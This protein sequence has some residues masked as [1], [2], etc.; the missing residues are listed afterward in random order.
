MRMKR[1]KI[2]PLII[3]SAFL[4]VQGMLFWSFEMMPHEND[5]ACPVLQAVGD[6]P[7]EN[8][9]AMIQHHLSAMEKF[10]SGTPIASY[11]LLVFI[12]AVFVFVAR[13]VL[14]GAQGGVVRFYWTRIRIQTWQKFRHWLAMITTRFRMDN[15]RASVLVG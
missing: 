7:G 13:E 12:A 5:G 14:G 11:L 3:I 4:A 9:F 15:L 8:M 6:C 2:L 10:G 1:K